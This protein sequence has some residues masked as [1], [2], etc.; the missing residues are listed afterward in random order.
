[1]IPD[2]L[3]SSAIPNNSALLCPSIL[4]R[5]TA[6]WIFAYFSLPNLTFSIRLGVGLGISKCLSSQYSVIPVIGIFA[7]RLWHILWGFESVQGSNENALIL[8]HLYF[9]II[10]LSQVSRSLG[11]CGSGNTWA[12]PWDHTLG[13]HSGMHGSRRTWP[14]AE[15]SVNSCALSLAPHV[16]L[17]HF[18]LLLWGNSGRDFPL[19]S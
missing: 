19:L 11:P 8:F 1:M 4:A 15:Y 5:S 7:M 17:D 10:W 9:L 14:S 6:H 16:L 18:S 3:V 2:N 12:I 13:S